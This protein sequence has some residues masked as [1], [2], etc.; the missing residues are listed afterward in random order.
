MSILSKSAIAHGDGTCTVEKVRIGEPTSDEVL[1]RMMASGICHTDYDSLKWG[2]PLVMGHEDAGIVAQKGSD[3]TGITTGDRVML[4]W[5]TPCGSCPRCYEGSLHLCSN[6]SPVIA[7]NNGY[8][9]GH[10]HRDGT[11]WKQKPI[12][13]AF[14]LGT[15]SEYALV[16]S[17]AVVPLTDNSITFEAASMIGCGVMTGYGSVMRTAEVEPGSS[18]AVLGC[19]GVGLNVIQACRI[20]GAETI[21]AID[22]SNDKLL[23]AARLGATHT[24][25]SHPDDVS[26]QKVTEQIQ[27][28]TSLSGT[29]YA[30]ECTAVPALGAAPLALIR[31][32]GM[33]IQVSGIEEEITVDMSLF[34]WDKTYINPLYGQCNPQ[35]D[36]PE[37]V[38]HCA[39]GKL[40]LD[41]MISQ[42]Y[43]LDQIH[44]ALNAL[45]KG[46]NIKSIIRF[47]ES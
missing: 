20:A 30:F 19:G 8:T 29:D 2:R 46:E 1:V 31:N 11:R 5:A 28:V 9:P 21:I 17:S 24:I 35:V 34:E 47:E 42:T 40:N 32:G 18:V 22:I 33:A 6:N 45:E 10:A 13:R 27:S 16:K 36:F 14:N 26:M 25:E 7:G 41:E 44:D 4:N 43:H 39:T 37:I 15:L 3:V 23:M 38:R 12:M